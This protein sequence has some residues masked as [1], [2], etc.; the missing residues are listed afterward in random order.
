MYNEGPKVWPIGE[1]ALKEFY[2]LKKLYCGTMQLEHKV[3]YHV[4]FYEHQL[5]EALILDQTSWYN[6]QRQENYWLDYYN[7]RTIDEVK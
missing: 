2:F 6:S 3:D 7:K 5:R 4:Y 1:M